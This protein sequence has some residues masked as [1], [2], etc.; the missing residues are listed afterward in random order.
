MTFASVKSFE[1]RGD[2]RLPFVLQPDE[3]A[4][5]AEPF[6]HTT[7]EE[8]LVRRV[9]RDAKQFLH[10]TSDVGGFVLPEVIDIRFTDG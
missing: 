7:R 2:L 9:S 6:E 10:V 4:T 8:N 5:D 1:G 3:V